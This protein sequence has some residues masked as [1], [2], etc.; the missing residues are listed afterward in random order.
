MQM[1]QFLLLY[2]TNETIQCYCSVSIE[3]IS[4]RWFSQRREDCLLLFSR[5]RFHSESDRSSNPSVS[6]NVSFCNLAN[7]QGKCDTA[8]LKN[9][10]NITGEN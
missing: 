6:R 9:K 5:Q 2:C 10:E 4:F 8:L 1:S 3:T 7:R